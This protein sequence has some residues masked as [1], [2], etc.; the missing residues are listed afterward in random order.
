MTDERSSYSADL[1]DGRYDC[2]DRIVLNAYNT[3]CYAPG[4]FRHWWRQLRD[5]SDAEV[6]NAHLMRMAGRFSRR[7]RGFAKANGIPVIDCA[8]GERKHETAGAYLSANPEARRLFLILVSRAVAP[9]W[10]VQRSGAGALRD[11]ARKKPYVNHYSF[12]IVDPEWGHLTIKMSGHPPFGAQVILN[13][14]EY[15]ACRA[16]RAGIGFVKEGNCFARLSDAAGLARIADTLSDPGAIGRLSR[17]C[18][19]W[20]YTSCLCFALDPAEQRR[21]GFRYAYS[22]YPVEYSRNMLFHLGG[23]MDQVFRGMVDRTRARLDVRRLR[24][25]FGA[26]TRPHRDRADR[27]PRLAVVVERPTYDLTVFKLHSGKL[28]LK[29]YTKGEHVLRFEAIAHNP[30][31]LGCGRVVAKFPDIVSRLRRILEGFRDNLHRADVA[32]LAGDTLDRLPSPSR[33]GKTRVGG[34]DLNKPR[35]RAVLAAVLAL[36][37]SPKGFGVA[38]FAAKV[39][40]IGGPTGPDHGTRRAAYDLKKLRGKDLITKVESAHRYRVP[41]P[42]SRTIA[43]LVILRDQVIQPILAGVSKPKLGRKP[44]NWSRLDEHYQTL[45]TDMR[46]LFQDLHLEAA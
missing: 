10:D 34:V 20:S 16:R 8:A 27:A 35:M 11:I 17:V 5:G 29:A 6:D 19:R 25:I 4:G 18:E 12:H 33:V 36:A 42:A 37:P 38:E 9:V 14:H 41:P 40:E 45:R 21:S 2:V 13:G 3:L 28:T 15:V 32:F 44:K 22:V 23:Q 43:A 26:K 39:R 31:E 7:V 46:A 30:K 24:T 1:L